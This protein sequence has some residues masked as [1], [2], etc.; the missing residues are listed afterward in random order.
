MKNWLMKCIKIFLI[1]I[2]YFLKIW[3]NVIVI[4]F[5]LEI[6]FH[7]KNFNLLYGF[8]YQSHV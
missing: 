2:F 3:T 8:F 6:P 5:I 7:L 1:Y 4:N